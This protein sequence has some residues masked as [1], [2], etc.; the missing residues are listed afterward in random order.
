MISDHNPMIWH[1]SCI[2]WCF[3]S[4]F[5]IMVLLLSSD[6]QLTHFD[7]V[8]ENNMVILPL[9]SAVTIFFPISSLATLILSSL[10]PSHH[11]LFWFFN[12]RTN[13]LNFVSWWWWNHVFWWA[14][15][16]KAEN[17]LSD[18]RESSLVSLAI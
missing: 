13:N 12:Y 10:L 9:L 3:V 6:D 5:G 16:N 7:N 14:I 18:K 4:C 11:I 8:D 2:F 15:I 17:W 1:D